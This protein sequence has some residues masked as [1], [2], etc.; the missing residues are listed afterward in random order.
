MNSRVWKF[1]DNMMLPHA[2]CD[3][4]ADT[5]PPFPPHLRL[6]QEGHGSTE[7]FH[8][9]ISNTLLALYLLDVT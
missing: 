8:R 5:V 7:L 6:H 3:V 9:A 1:H 4:L 2:P